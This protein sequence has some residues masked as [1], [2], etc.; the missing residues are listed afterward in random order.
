MNADKIYKKLTTIRNSQGAGIHLYENANIL[1]LHLSKCAGTSISKK[2]SSHFKEVPTEQIDFKQVSD[3][4]DKYFSFTIVR[5]IYTKIVSQYNYE[6]QSNLHAMNFDSWLENVSKKVRIQGNNNCFSDYSNEYNE[7]SQKPFCLLD[8]QEYLSHVGRFEDLNT[9]ANLL[10]KKTA[11]DISFPMLNKT[12][13]KIKNV[14]DNQ[15][16]IIE[17]TFKEEIRYFGFTR[18]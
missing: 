3:N 8:G 17:D 4:F 11:V 5:N 14:P 9:T 16:K 15:I 12:N 10:S 1:F 2:L 6:L 13:Y 18:S 7:L